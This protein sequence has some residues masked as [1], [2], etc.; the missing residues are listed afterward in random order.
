MKKIQIN[1][2]KMFQ[3]KKSPVCLCF[4]PRSCEANRFAFCAT[5]SLAGAVVNR[6][7]A[8]PP[9]SFSQKKNRMEIK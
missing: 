4:F 7:S 5:L 2:G 8:L 6:S 9:G 3:A 1:E